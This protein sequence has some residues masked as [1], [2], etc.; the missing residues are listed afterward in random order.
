MVFECLC[1][2]LN[3]LL[4]NNHWHYETNISTNGKI[5]I[6]CV[7]EMFNYCRILKA[8]KI[9]HS[10]AICQLVQLVSVQHP[11]PIGSLGIHSSTYSYQMLPHLPQVS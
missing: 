2:I 10:M 3:I 7:L 1:G 9:T 5:M 8:T 4:T 11:V 6:T